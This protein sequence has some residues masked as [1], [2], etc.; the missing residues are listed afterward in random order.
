[1]DPA[2]R[3]VMPELKKKGV[4]LDTNNFIIPT[5]LEGADTLI[6]LIEQVCSYGFKNK[7]D[8]SLC[9]QAIVKLVEIGMPESAGKIMSLLTSFGVD[10]KNRLPAGM[11]RFDSMRMLD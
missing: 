8:L 9:G 7:V 10:P 1:M 5:A 3:K 4:Y 6:Q 2:A 11:L